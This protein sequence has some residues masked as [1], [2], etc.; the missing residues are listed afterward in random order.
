MTVIY[1]SAKYPT[2]A[3]NPSQFEPNWIGF[4]TPANLLNAD[5]V[6]A[7]AHVCG[8]QLANTPVGSIAVLF[9]FDDQ[10]IANKTY[11]VSY[12]I[13]VG[14]YATGT[15]IASNQL[16][17]IPYLTMVCGIG[18][19]L[20]GEGLGT[21][22]V[23]LNGVGNLVFTGVC[24]VQTV[25]GNI[26]MPGS[27]LSTLDKMRLQL[28]MDVL[29]TTSAVS[30]SGDL[31]LDF[32]RLQ[33]GIQQG[34]GL[35]A[36]YRLPQLVQ[37]VGGMTHSW[38]Q[39]QQATAQD[40]VLTTLVAGSSRSNDRLQ[41]SNYGFHVSGDRD[42]AGV[43]GWLNVY[44]TAWPTTYNFAINA[45]DGVEIVKAGVVVAVNSSQAFPQQIQLANN[46]NGHWFVSET[47]AP[48]LPGFVAPVGHT[49]NSPTVAYI[50]GQNFDGFGNATTNVAA[51]SNVIISYGDKWGT[52]LTPADVNAVN[53]GISYLLLN[54]TNDSTLVKLQLDDLPLQ[55][56]Y[57]KPAVVESPGDEFGW[58]VLGPT[59]NPLTTNAEFGWEAGS[60]ALQNVLRPN[61]AEFGW[62][63][64]SV[65]ASRF[66]SVDNIGAEFGWEESNAGLG[67]TIHPS[68]NQFGWEIGGLQLNPIAPEFTWET[69][70]P[71]IFQNKYRGTPAF[72]IHTVHPNF[73][74]DDVGFSSRTVN[75]QPGPRIWI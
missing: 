63:A 13:D 40:S 10:P 58:E 1:T 65:F 26:V 12:T 17:I 73:R 64:A 62:E 37:S 46:V 43:F 35:T 21:N 50:L 33:Y 56:Y 36:D 16:V 19:A 24:A 44:S 59:I 72:R 41:A 34:V 11:V 39:P 75:A 25:S 74:R 14:G 6:F 23:L 20:S 51:S 45:A 4:D 18:V 32:I 9:S 28:W 54:E 68:H 38:S 5:G 49:G 42:V 27:V 52:D 69:S 70:T 7:S 71:D 22:G 15:L 55:I 8:D 48:Y 30:V 60:P 47:L 53:F 31:Q 67:F 3:Y 61:S 29:S 66:Q 57:T 2:S